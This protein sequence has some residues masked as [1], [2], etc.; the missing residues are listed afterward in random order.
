MFQRV[1]SCDNVLVPVLVFD[2]T[3]WVNVVYVL[4]GIYYNWLKGA[5]AEAVALA[6]AE[7]SSHFLLSPVLACWILLVSCGGGIC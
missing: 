3:A 1:P 5:M 6:S 2:G 7:N 4:A